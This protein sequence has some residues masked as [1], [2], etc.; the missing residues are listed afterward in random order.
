MTSFLPVS[1]GT[2]SD[3]DRI[4]Y[5]TFSVKYSGHFFLFCVSP[6]KTVKENEEFAT[7]KGT[8]QEAVTTESRVL[9]LKTAQR[10]SLHHKGATNMTK[11]TFNL[12]KID[13]KL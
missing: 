8:Q 3:I 7:F 1:Y 12:P 6:H 4:N 10:T 9:H 2:S 13:L 11:T 5:R